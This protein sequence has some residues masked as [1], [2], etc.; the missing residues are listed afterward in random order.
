MKKWYL[1]LNIDDELSNK[2]KK[3]V[4]VIGEDEEEIVIKALKAYLDLKLNA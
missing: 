2:I 3:I 4:D 1:E